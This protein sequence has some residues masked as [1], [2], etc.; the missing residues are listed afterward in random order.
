MKEKTFASIPY[1]V[2]ARN[3]SSQLT[4][5]S[6]KRSMSI[7]K[8]I[9]VKLRNWILQWIA[10]NCP[11]NSIRIQLHRWRGVAIGKGVMLGMHCILDNAHPEYIVLEDYTAL[12]G[13]NYVITHSNPY[14]HYKG[15]LLSY[16]APVVLRKGAWAGVSSTLLPG[17]EIGECSVISAGSTVS[18]KIPPNVIVCGNP[19]TIIKEFQPNEEIFSCYK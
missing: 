14:L 1:Y 18:G 13:N 8:F 16:L 9:W 2:P 19:A 15:R 7:P 5:A 6:D 3:I 4:A 11:V 10:Y 17:T 12:A